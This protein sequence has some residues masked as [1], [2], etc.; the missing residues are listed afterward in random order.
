MKNTSARNAN[1]RLIHLVIYL[2]LKEIAWWIKKRLIPTFGKK[3]VTAESRLY[4]EVVL[5]ICLNRK[6]RPNQF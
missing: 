1:Q 3:K 2:F 4:F 6:S 5:Y